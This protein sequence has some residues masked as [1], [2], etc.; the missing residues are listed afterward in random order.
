[1]WL[2]GPIVPWTQDGWEQLTALS[3]GFCP[4]QMKSLQRARHGLLSATNVVMTFNSNLKEKSGTPVRDL[5]EGC[6]TSAHVFTQRDIENQEIKE[7]RGEEAE[8]GWEG[9]SCSDLSLLPN[10][11]PGWGVSSEARLLGNGTGNSRI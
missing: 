6:E 2:L 5:G 10:Q 8:E 11:W 9:G 4:S 1:M 3:P 7:K